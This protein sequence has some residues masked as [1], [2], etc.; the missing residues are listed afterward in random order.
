MKKHF[1]V[2][3]KGGFA[4]ILGLSLAFSSQSAK[5]DTFTFTGNTIGESPTWTRPTVNNDPGTTLALV[6]GGQGWVAQ[7][8]TVGTSGTYT[9]S[10]VATGTGTGD[11]NST[12]NQA[13]LG[14]LYDNSFN[15]TD[16]LTNE[17]KNGFGSASWTF[18][19]V[20]GTDY[21]IVVTGFC[22][23]GSG[24]GTT[25]HPASC[26]GPSTQEEG[27]FS[28]S[29][30]GPGTI[31]PLTLSGTNVPEPGSLALV[32]TGLSALVGVVRRRKSKA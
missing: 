12:T 31:T 19:L 15:P 29:I 6:G 1:S 16:P 7:E 8:F 26:R 4:A 14:F 27:P 20:A 32:G 18:N 21:W 10:A 2:A 28:A 13:I 3:F 11:W 5:A 22:G 30:S 25:N 9:Y 24:A 17:L 23:T